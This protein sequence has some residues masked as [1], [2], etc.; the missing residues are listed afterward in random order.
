MTRDHEWQVGT[1]LE[2]TGM[3]YIKVLSQYSL[4]KLRRFKII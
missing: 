2:E 4:E 3:V 1:D